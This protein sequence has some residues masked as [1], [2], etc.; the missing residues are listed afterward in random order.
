MYIA[1]W[2][3]CN[4]RFISQ[5]PPPHSPT[6]ALGVANKNT[7]PQKCLG[8]RWHQFSSNQL[9]LTERKEGPWFGPRR[10]S[11]RDPG[12]L[13]EVIM[14]SCTMVTNQENQNKIPCGIP[15]KTDFCRHSPDP[16]NWNLGLKTTLLRCIH[17][18]S[19]SSSSWVIWDVKTTKQNSLSLTLR[20]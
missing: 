19:T 6:N 9:S 11:I 18:T 4:H 5:H 10:K 3:A 8:G 17:S 15:F 12:F 7:A 1:F 13:R 14:V 20:F 16:M 2:F